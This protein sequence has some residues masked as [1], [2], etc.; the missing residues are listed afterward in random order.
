MVRR[1]RLCRVGISGRWRQRGGEAHLLVTHPATE[2]RPLYSADGT[3]MAFVFD[4]DGSWD[5][6]TLASEKLTQV[7]DPGLRFD[8]AAYEAGKGDQAG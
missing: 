2:S 5:Y 3:K 8:L 6:L 4:A 7:G 1:L